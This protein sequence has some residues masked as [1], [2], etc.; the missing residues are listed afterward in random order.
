MACLHDTIQSNLG[1]PFI[2]HSTKVLNIPIVICGTQKDLTSV[3]YE[4]IFPE[5]C[6]LL[7]LDI[8]KRAILTINEISPSYLF[9]EMNTVLFLI[10]PEYASRHNCPSRPH[11]LASKLSLSSQLSHSNEIQ[12]VVVTSRAYSFSLSAAIS[13]SFPLFSKKTKLDILHQVFVF[14][15]SVD[16]EFQVFPPNR[17]SLSLLSDGIRRAQQIVDSPTNEMDTDGFLN[18]IEQVFTL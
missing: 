9:C 17:Y 3:S 11:S 6:S 16:G 12:I 14:F 5:E 15:V 18:Q 10:L 13:R 2:C 4:S 1:P 8:W 7:P